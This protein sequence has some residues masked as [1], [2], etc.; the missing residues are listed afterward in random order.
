MIFQASP[1]E[2]GRDTLPELLPIFTFLN[3]HANKLYQEGYF[4]KLN[5]LDNNG[6]ANADRNW[7]EC[8]AQLVGTVLSLWDAAALDAAGQDGE[9][10]PTFINLAD[11]S[12]KMIETLPTRNN[13]VEPLHNVL[14]ISTA[15][16]NRYL[17]HFNSLHSLTQWTAG[18]RL[19]MFENASLQ[20]LYTGSLIAG[21]GKELNNIRTIM[22]RTKF[23]SED[24]AR[25]RF[26]AG[27]AWQR[28]WC[29]ITPPDE[30]DFQKHQKALRKRSAYERAPVLKGDVKFY[31]TKKTKKAVPI[32]TIREAYAAYAI[33]PQSKPLIEQSTLIKIEGKITIHST[34]ESTTE[35]FVFVMPEVHAAVSGFEMMLRTLFPVYDVF[36]L[37]G[38]PNRLVADTLD[39][40]GLMFAM[41]KER[42]YGYLD[43]M[44]VAALV[45]TEGSDTWSEREWRKRLKDCTARRMTSAPPSR[46][47]SR[48]GSQRGSRA[49][50]NTRSRAGSL[51]LPD[52]AS[53]RSTSIEFNRSSDA[54]FATPKKSGTG[55]PGQPL[56]HN[57]HARS[58]SDTISFTPPRRKRSATVAS[59][60]SNE[61][62]MDEDLL[63]EPPLPPA[64]LTPVVSASSQPPAEAHDRSSSE[65]D[66]RP[67]EA[68]TTEVSEA[69]RPSSPPAPVTA[70]PAF[71]HQPS[72]K[73][74]HRPGGGPENRGHAKQMSTS[75]LSQMAEVN[76]TGGDTAATG[77]A[78]AWRSRENAR[79]PDQSGR[80]VNQSIE[81]RRTPADQRIALQG[82]ITDPLRVP[83]TELSP[84]LSAGIVPDG[85]DTTTSPPGSR[86]IARKPVGTPVPPPVPKYLGY[87]AI[88][89][90]DAVRSGRPSSRGT[91][92]QPGIAAIGNQSSEHGRPI[93]PEEFVRERAAG[94][95]KPSPVYGHSRDQSKSSTNLPLDQ[96]RNDWAYK[97]A[98]PPRPHSRG[99]VSTPNGDWAHRKELP[100][101][102][103]TRGAES[104]DYGSHLSAREQEHV[105]RMTNTPL[106]N[107][108]NSSNPSYGSGG[109]VGAIAAREQ[110]KKLI[111]EGLSNHAVQ[112]A[113][114]Q[115]NQQAQQAANM[116]YAPGFEGRPNMPGGWA[117]S[118]QQ[119]PQ[120]T[121]WTSPQA[122]VYWNGVNP[123]QNQSQW[124]PLTGQYHGTHQGPNNNGGF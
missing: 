17:L 7:T 121:Q 6:R 114:A 24:W 113:I 79:T 31:D 26:G 107:I 110:E 120:A 84:I 41:P 109:L 87:N 82:V 62:D 21:K 83:R 78:A 73:P 61:L 98:L 112:Q 47:G 36:G 60:L 43:L 64:H 117:S 5:D 2:I 4:L 97:K 72:D 23:K 80:G 56:A 14:S 96:T 28:Y 93:T 66:V 69:L 1:A 48:L 115:R 119:V 34:P 39:Q 77:A 53:V 18:I 19:A 42:R 51:R 32:A 20:E 25:V 74:H 104:T 12:I 95:R 37:Y 13:D 102:P 52:D 29:V 49:T 85:R 122:S 108:S 106:V 54:V 33:Y 88:Q 46:T 100:P 65:D 118:T 92:W 45:C 76:G 50:Y 16:K 55:P 81:A 91:P 3:S 44:D 38:R 59:H 15:G 40:R 71:A 63:E 67:P 58:A 116:A 10:P 9:V 70:P 68:A 30:K 27:T 103:Q 57:Y 86:G 101:R 8:F 22:D 90:S 89:E 105:A 99:G 94:N 124:N 75:T 11:A 123:Q 35:G 111:K